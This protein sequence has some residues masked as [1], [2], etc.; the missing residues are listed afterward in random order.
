MVELTRLFR[1]V[2]G[3]VMLAG[4]AQSGV[5]P[6]GGI[7]PNAEFAHRLAAAQIE[8]HW[9]CIPDPSGLTVE[10]FVRN[11]GSGEIKFVELE[12]VSLN[13]Q[14]TVLSEARTA[15]EPVVLSLR[16]T[17]P[18]RARVETAGPAPHLD[19]FYKY[20][21]GVRRDEQRF[22][23]RNICSPALFRGH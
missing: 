2:L 15:I 4:C 6:A 17:G 5:Q 8:I 1:T 11:A 14:G 20:R 9:N 7:D 13:P 3:C 19:L 10:G 22:S 21:V 12:M 18:F 16:D 23:A